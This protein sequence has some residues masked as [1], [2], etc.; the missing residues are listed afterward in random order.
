MIL[1]NQTLRLNVISKLISL[2][3]IC[4]LKIDPLPVWWASHW[5]Q[6]HSRKGKSHRHVQ[7]AVENWSAPLY[8][9]RSLV[10]QHF[11]L[12][13]ALL[14]AWVGPSPYCSNPGKIRMESLILIVFSFIYLEMHRITIHRMKKQSDTA[15]RD[16]SYRLV[17]G[18]IK[19]K[20]KHRG[21]GSWAM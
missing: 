21:I 6:T 19:Q 12:I 14:L 18:E 13:K 15:N 11:E 9:W 3:I 7:A 16:Y 8:G 5:I 20:H 17:G 10:V 2:R 4:S 1:N